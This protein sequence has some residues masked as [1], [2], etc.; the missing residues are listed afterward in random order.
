M[1]K[2]RCS[3]CGSDPLYTAYHD[4]EWGVPVYDNERKHFENL[5]LESA[6]AGLSWITIL[7]RRETYRLAYK[8]F[9]PQVIASWG[10]ED[11]LRLLQ[12]PG[13]I[14]NRRKIES[15]IN[16]ARCFLVVK[17][18][19][20]SFSDYYWH[21]QEGRPILNN[22]EKEEQIPAL[23]SLSEIISKDMKKRGFSFL[24]PTVTYAN[25]QSV[26]MVNDHLR[27]CFRYKEVIDS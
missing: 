22:W 15:S 7:K 19:F 21:F 1:S 25:M 5:I 9:D 12:D 11:V 26:G 16:N 13:V 10:E 8:G 3:W 14:R 18:E 6:Q 17:E 2:Q 4:E 20:G 24:G 27:S 23:T